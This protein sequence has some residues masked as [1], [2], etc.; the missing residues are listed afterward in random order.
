[1]T[2]NPISDLSYPL[3]GVTI[4]QLNKFV[5][6]CGGRSVFDGKTTTDVN[7]EIQVLKQKKSRKARTR[8]QQ[9]SPRL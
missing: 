3:E 8:T 6:D 7:N 4:H 5:D 1:M 2:T 9:S